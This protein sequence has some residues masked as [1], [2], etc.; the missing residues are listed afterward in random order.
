MTHH[1]DDD[2]G[3]GI[4]RRHALECMIWAGTGVLWTISG[5]VPVSLNLLGAAQAAE[6]MATGFTFLQISDSHIGFDK[7][8]NPHAI[9]TL[10][11]AMGKI[12][13]LPQKPA[14]LI[15]T[16]DITH[17][18]KPAQFD[19]AAQIIG[20][21]GFDVH[22]VPGEHDLID[23][24]N[25][26]AYLER[27]GK[28]TKGAGWYSFDQNGV[29]FVALVNVVNLKAG[30]LGNLGA[31][32]LAWL[33]DDLKAVS[34]S[35]PV[36]VFAHIPLWAVYP[37]WGWGTDDAA[38]ALGLLKRFGSVTVLNGH[39]H[40]IMQKVEGNVTF[41][42]ARSTAF[43]QP[44]PGTAASP[45]PMTV[46]AGQLRSLLGTSR[47]MVKQGGQDLAIIDSTLADA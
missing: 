34:A 2:G 15:H 41:H 23:E 40:Q 45:G 11:E 35:T 27:Y 39:I 12:Q 18:S 24:G 14:F 8:A 25:G 13:A 16:G 38:Q 4:S 19:N 44:A 37:E 10:K 7:A 20:G 32:Q 43:P 5:G 47:V 46:P 6:A 22:Y 29:H 28:G 30:G 21:A 31:E 33:A 36:V 3:D 17:L 9:D 42:T 1:H 26:Q